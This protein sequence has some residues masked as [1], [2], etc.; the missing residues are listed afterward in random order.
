MLSKIRKCTSEDI[1]AQWTSN[2]HCFAI[3]F[4]SKQSLLS[5]SHDDSKA[6]D[7]ALLSPQPD[8]EKCLCIPEVGALLS[9]N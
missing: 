7:N 6:A 3:N 4:C 8:L 2:Q 5:L 9:E 1:V